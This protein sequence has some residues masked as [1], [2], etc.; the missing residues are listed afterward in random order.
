M[1][2]LSKMFEEKGNMK[3]EPLDKI[4]MFFEH[5]TCFS[6]VVNIEDDYI[7]NIGTELEK[8]DPRAYMNGYNWTAF[9]EC[10]LRKFSPYYLDKLEH[11]PEAG[12]YA[13][14]ISKDIEGSE[15]IAKQ[16]KNILKELF[17]SPSLL[18]SIVSYLKDDIHWE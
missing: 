10:F 4:I 8:I 2:F 12:T 3:T 13:G 1:N 9:I 5:E 6:V 15:L 14:I 16:F 11:D 18:I 7:M 17:N